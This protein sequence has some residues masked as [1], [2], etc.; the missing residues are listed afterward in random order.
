MANTDM[1][2]APTSKYSYFINSTLSNPSPQTLDIGLIVNSNF[3]NN[4]TPPVINR[5][6]N[7]KIAHPF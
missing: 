4:A 3:T 1:I 7:N 5:L 6:F 2:V